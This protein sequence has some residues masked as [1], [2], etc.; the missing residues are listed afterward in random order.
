MLHDIISDFSC[1]N[2]PD[3]EHFLH[4]SAVE[5]TKK[6]QSV[7]YLVFN[8]EDASLLLEFASATVMKLK[9][10]VGGVMEFLN[11]SEPHQLNQLLK[12][13]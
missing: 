7:T 11:D 8:S 1:P 12:I 2:N 4:N 10:S 13:L 6:D 9:Y 5:F 3:V